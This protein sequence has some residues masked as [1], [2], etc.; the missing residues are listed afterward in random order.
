[1]RPSVRYYC[2]YSIFYVYKLRSVVK[3]FT[4]P[5]ILLYCPLLLN[6]TF[7]CQTTATMH[8]L[9]PP[10]QCSSSFESDSSSSSFSDSASHSPSPISSIS[11]VSHSPL[12]KLSQKRI[13]V[14]P[15]PTFA[16]VSFLQGLAS[17]LQKGAGDLVFL[18]VH[19]SNGKD[20]DKDAMDT[21]LRKCLMEVD[22]DCVLWRQVMADVNGEYLS[23]CVIGY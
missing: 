12:P 8:T 13:V 1:V 7:P 21:L 22:S 2:T 4:P 3:L 16:D 15:S 5:R 11:S 20:H 18:L 14:L 9:L 19:S 10:I 6:F 23:S 17:T